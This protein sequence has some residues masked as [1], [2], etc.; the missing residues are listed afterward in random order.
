MTVRNVLIE[1][2]ALRRTCVVAIALLAGVPAVAS[3][4]PQHRATTAQS[5]K[6]PAAAR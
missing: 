4:V 2:V 5:N 6:F 3:A 1:A